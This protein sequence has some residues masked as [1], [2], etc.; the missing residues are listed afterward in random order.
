MLDSVYLMV[1]LIRSIERK[2]TEV[3]NRADP[4]ETVYP[5]VFNPIAL[6]KAKTPQR[7][8]CSECNRVKFLVRY[9]LEEFFISL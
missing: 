7:F 3:S 4:D 1:I 6:R 5:L 8:G 2:T 9:S